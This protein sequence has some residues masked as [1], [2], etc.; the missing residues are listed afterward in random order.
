MDKEESSNMVQIRSKTVDSLDYLSVLECEVRV[1][2]DRLQPHD[3][4]HLH[5]TINVL[6]ERIEEIRGEIR[7]QIHS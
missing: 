7:A 3:T 5:T 2:H 4:G 6:N 1:L